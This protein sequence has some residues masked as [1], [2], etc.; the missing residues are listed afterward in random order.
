MISRILSAVIRLVIRFYQRI[1]NPMLKFTAGPGVG[2]RFSPTCSHYFLQAVELHGP[3]RGSW[4]GICRIF[5]CHPWGGSGYDPVPPTDDTHDSQ[6]PCS[7]HGEPP[8]S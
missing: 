6:H 1:L 3:F 5:R 2:C 7:C 8:H 4:Y